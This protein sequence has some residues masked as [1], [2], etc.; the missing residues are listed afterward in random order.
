M[1]GDARAPRDGVHAGA[2]CGDDAMA[3]GHR[4]RSRH[5]PRSRPSAPS[6]SARSSNTIAHQLLPTSESML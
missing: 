3:A 6:S 1:L 4:H 5:R 2:P